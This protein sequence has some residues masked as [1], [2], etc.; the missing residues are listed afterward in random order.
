M[1]EF[2]SPSPRRCDGVSRRGFLKV[3]SL[4]LAGLTLA[5][6]L[7]ARA[8]ASGGNGASVPDRSR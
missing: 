3:G 7:R 4:G 5:D 6:A 1:L 8:F 2:T